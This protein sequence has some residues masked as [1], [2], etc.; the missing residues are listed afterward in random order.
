MHSSPAAPLPAQP[1][2]ARSGPPC[3]SSQPQGRPLTKMPRPAP[4][5]GGRGGRPC[6]RPLCPSRPHT[7]WLWGGIGCAAVSQ[8]RLGS[9]RP[10]LHTAYGTHS[11]WKPNREYL[12]CGRTSNSGCSQDAMVYGFGELEWLAGR[13]DPPWAGSCTGDATM[14]TRAPAVRAS[15][16]RRPVVEGSWDTSSTL[17]R[18]Q[19]QQHVAATTTSAGL[20]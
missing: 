15:S 18:Q 8:H 13:R 12:Y 17:W 20:A 9:P 7:S 1:C 11:L 3:H 14:D 5:S 10:M 16:P 6:P 4:T 2:P 19:Q